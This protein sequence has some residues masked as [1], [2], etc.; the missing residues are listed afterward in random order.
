MKIIVAKGSLLN[1]AKTE[2]VLPMCGSQM[3]KQF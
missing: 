1:I 2:L 3:K